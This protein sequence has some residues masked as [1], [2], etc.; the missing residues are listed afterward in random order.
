M[1]FYA[2]INLVG[3]GRPVA[4]RCLDLGSSKSRLLH[5]RGYGI[6]LVRE[7][8]DP[9]G[10]FPYVG[11]PDQTGAPAGGAV[12]ERDQW[13]LVAPDPLLGVAPQPI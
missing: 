10:H 5:E 11:S 3:I 13:M 9:H 2:G 7:I 8:L 12:T 1:Q 4:E 6:G